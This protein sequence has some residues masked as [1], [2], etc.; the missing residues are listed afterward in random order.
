MIYGSSYTRL[1]QKRC[2][3]L[4]SIGNGLSRDGSNAMSTLLSVWKIDGE[5]PVWCCM[6]TM[7]DALQAEPNG[8][9][10]ASMSWTQKHWLA[11]ME[12]CLQLAREHGMQRL[13]LETDSQVLVRLWEKRLCQNSEVG[14]ILQQIQDLRHSFVEF[15]FVYS[16]RECNTSS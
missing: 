7:E 13:R 4:G 8:M 2:S 14:P 1:S 5:P 6:I 12:C 16:S 9:T 11:T 15:S 10:V 3:V